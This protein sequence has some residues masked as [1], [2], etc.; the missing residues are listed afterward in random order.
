M[1][2]MSDDSLIFQFHKG[3]IKTDMKVDFLMPIPI[4]QFHKGTIKTQPGE[5]LPIF[6]QISIP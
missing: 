4:F 3:T 2:R 5:L 6:Y 1:S